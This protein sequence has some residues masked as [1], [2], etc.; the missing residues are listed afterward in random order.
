MASLRGRPHSSRE[1][2]TPV[3]VNTQTGK[4]GKARLKSQPLKFEELPDEL[5]TLADALAILLERMYVSYHSRVPYSQ[6]FSSC[7]FCD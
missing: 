1:G 6:M 5:E 2:S 3:I 7:S 4:R